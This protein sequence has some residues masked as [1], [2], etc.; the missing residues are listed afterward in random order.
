MVDVNNAFIGTINVTGSEIGAFL[1]IEQ[2]SGS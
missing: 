2:E 1:S